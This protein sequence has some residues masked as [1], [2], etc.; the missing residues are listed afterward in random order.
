[1]RDGRVEL[2]AGG[3]PPRGT[4][5]ILKQPEGVVVDAAGQLLVADRL[6]DAVVRLDPRGEVLDRGLVK[7]PRPRLLAA[8]AEQLWVAA[9]GTAEAPWQRGP[10]ELWRVGANGQ[11]TLVLRGPVAAGMA[12]GLADWLL[13]GGSSG[14]AHLRAESRWSA[15]RVRPLQRG[16]R[17][18]RAGLRAGDAGD[19][20]GRHRR[21]SVRGHGDPGRLA[22]ERGR[23]DHR[24]LRS[25]HARERPSALKA[26]RVLPSPA[27]RR[28]LELSFSSQSMM[29][30]AS[31]PLSRAGAA[32]AAPSSLRAGG[33]GSARGAGTVRGGVA[34]RATAGG[35]STAGRVGGS[36][37]AAAARRT[38]SIAGRG[39]RGRRERCGGAATGGGSGGGDGRGSPRAAGA[40]RPRAR[41]RGRQRDGRGLA[42]GRRRRGGDR[43][44][45]GPWRYRA[46]HA[47]GCSGELATSSQ[48]TSATPPPT[49]STMPTASDRAQLADRGDAAAA[50]ASGC[51]V[52]ENGLTSLQR[53]LKKSV[54]SR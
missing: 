54:M 50:A 20:E 29:A 34:G 37:S 4:P 6:Q 26:R 47:A 53:S 46:R 43:R 39:G 16:R 23:P 45:L 30:P 48:L 28:A 52:L 38:D 2:L 5:P 15:G 22:G 25:V 14:G 36:T 40:G 18:A 31:S 42:R 49:T 41:R 44:G 51:V 3:T 12:V 35:A 19:S 27:Y 8:G 24:P 13:V 11:A 17:A 1:M 32:A 7:V 10:G 9:D 21:R 33:D